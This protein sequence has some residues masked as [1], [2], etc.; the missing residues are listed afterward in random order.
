MAWRIKGLCPCTFFLVLFVGLP[1][2][3]GGVYDLCL[4][5]LGMYAVSC[6]SARFIFS[7]VPCPSVCWDIGVLGR[8]NKPST[9]TVWV[10]LDFQG[11][12]FGVLFQLV[13][14]WYVL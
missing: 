1:G 9:S 14:L 5:G 8:F 11:S 2:F 10:V 7:A 12:L 3:L 6:A 4:C 13:G